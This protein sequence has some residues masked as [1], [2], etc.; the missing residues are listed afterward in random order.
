[1]T[2][3][4]GHRRCGAAASAI[5]S[6]MPPTDRQDARHGERVAQRRRLRRYL[7][8]RDRRVRYWTALVF[9]ALTATAAVLL[10]Q[11]VSVLRA[12]GPPP[13]P[14]RGIAED[15][16]SPT[17]ILSLDSWQLLRVDRPPVET[18]QKR[19]W[20]K[21]LGDPAA[22]QPALRARLNGWPRRLLVNRRRLPTDD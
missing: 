22:A 3:S 2:G 5:R 10:V 8:R 18:P 12:P 16:C 9:G 1:M 15:G 21:A 17:Q 13:V 14:A 20:E 11:F 19:L 6:A 7:Q 4:R